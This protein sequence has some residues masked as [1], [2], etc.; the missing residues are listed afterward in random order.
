M[1][2]KDIGTF[3]SSSNESS[4]DLST[5]NGEGSSEI[6]KQDIKAVEMESSKTIELILDIETIGQTRKR[7]NRVL[8]EVKK[9]TF[10]GYF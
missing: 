1:S 5:Q 9:N 2:P 4:V 10:Y 3:S 8:G 7:R 6:E